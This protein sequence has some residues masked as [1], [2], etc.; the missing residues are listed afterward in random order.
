MSKLL[1][2]S[3]TTRQ[4]YET[5]LVHVFNGFCMLPTRSAERQRR[6]TFYYNLCEEMTARFPIPTF[7]LAIFVDGDWVQS[8]H[9]GLNEQQARGWTERLEARGVRVKTEPDGVM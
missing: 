1:R 2:P 6:M 9:T 4:Q 7:R 5:A 3:F 8:H